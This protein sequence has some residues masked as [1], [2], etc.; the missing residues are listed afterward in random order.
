MLWP[1][2]VRWTWALMT[3]TAA[4]TGIKRLHIVGLLC[5]FFIS[6]RYFSRGGGTTSIWGGHGTPVPPLTT[7]MV[8]LPSTQIIVLNLFVPT[9]HPIFTP[10]PDNV[11]CTCYQATATHLHQNYVVSLLLKSFS[12]ACKSQTRLVW[13]APKPHT[14]PNP[15]HYPKNMLHLLC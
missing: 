12:V 3:R 15:L 1:L 14:P 13:N 6:S 4:Y 11:W 9:K 7:G 5:H 10:G 2:L 8:G